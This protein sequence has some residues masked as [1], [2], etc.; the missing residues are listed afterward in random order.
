MTLKSKKFTRPVVTPFPE[1]EDVIRWG[2]REQS[3][4]NIG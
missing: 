4:R 3:P 2:W 1:D